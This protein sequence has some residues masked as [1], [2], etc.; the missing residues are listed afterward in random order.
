MSNTVKILPLLGA[1]VL[2]AAVGDVAGADEDDGGSPS[3]EQRV[4]EI[5]DRE[6]I[7]DL[8]ETYGRML[9]EKDL[10]GYSNLFAQDGVWEGG[11]G[12]ATGPDE[13]YAMLDRVYGQLEPDAYGADYHIMSGIMIDVD[14]DEATSWSRWTWVVEGEDGKPVAQRS[15]HYEDVLVKIDGEWKF[16]HRL[17]VTELPTA[18][19][20]TEA[21]IFRRDHRELE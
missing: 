13:I 20:D 4:R 17:T 8:L 12:S 10:R 5:E 21:D 11:I 6:A 1:S 14:G 7:R 19:N 2:L 15:G 16:R 3:L 9:D 18:E